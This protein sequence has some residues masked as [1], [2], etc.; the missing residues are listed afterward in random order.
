MSVLL[1]NKNTGHL[2]LVKSDQDPHHQHD[3][4]DPSEHPSGHLSG[5]DALDH[6]HSAALFTFA[7]TLGPLFF[8]TKIIIRQ[9]PEIGLDLFFGF[10]R[11]PW[12]P[13]L[14]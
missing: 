4:D 1:Q 11:P 5:H 8:Q 14:T 13:I 10:D 12:A 3:L 6:T 7:C 2:M 9:E